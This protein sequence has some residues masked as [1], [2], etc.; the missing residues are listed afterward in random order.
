LHSM[1][2]MCSTTCWAWPAPIVE[3]PQRRRIPQDRYKDACDRGKDVAAAHKDTFVVYHRDLPSAFLTA[4][5]TILSGWR[6]RRCRMTCKPSKSGEMKQVPPPNRWVTS[7]P[8]MTPSSSP[9]TLRPD[10]RIDEV[11]RILLRSNA[12]C[13]G[14]APDGVFFVKVA[15]NDDTQDPGL[16]CINLADLLE[17]PRQLPLDCL[18][19]L[20]NKEECDLYSSAP[21][22]YVGK[23]VQTELYGRLPWLLGLLVFLSVSSA[24]LEFFDV[25]LQKHLII[26]FY[27]TALVGCGGNAGSQAASLV[28]QA[29]A[30]GELVPT[31]GDLWRVLRKEVLVALGIAATLS[32]GIAGRILLFGG[33]AVDALA[34]ALAMAVTVAFSVLFGASAPLLLQRAGADPAKVSG[35]LLSTVI[36][37]AGVLVACLSAQLLEA[38]GA[39]DTSVGD[40]L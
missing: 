19:G 2:P 21:E 4:T 27:L 16:A 6:C 17:A 39:W 33:S 37:I 40:K 5:A 34:I 20:G 9:I 25:L 35:P 8:V 29:L 13:V 1:V 3:G 10:M 11:I 28:L 18:L 23:S 32:L 36:D 15:Q 26:A 38:V 24:I 12:V 7:Q 22:P 31:F 30:T 14:D